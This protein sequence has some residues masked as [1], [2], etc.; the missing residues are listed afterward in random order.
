MGEFEPARL[1]AETM[2]YTTLPQVLEK[3]E[4]RFKKT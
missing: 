4:K 3:F 2:E 1:S